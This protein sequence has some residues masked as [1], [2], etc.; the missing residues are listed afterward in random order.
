MID[1]CRDFDAMTT[2]MLNGFVE[3]IP[4]HEQD[5]EGR[6]DTRQEV[7]IYFNFVEK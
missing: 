5:Q 2:T 1:K 6:Q 7:E 3:K 4:V